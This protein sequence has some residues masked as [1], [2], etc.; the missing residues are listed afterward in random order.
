L[1]G[2]ATSCKEK[3]TFDL[4]TDQGKKWINVENKNKKV[5]MQ[6]RLLFQKVA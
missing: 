2:V 1:P 5:M 4:D 3:D 6:F